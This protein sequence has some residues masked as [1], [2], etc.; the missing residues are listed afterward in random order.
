MPIPSVNDV[1]AVKAD[2]IL[3]KINDTIENE[4]LTKMIALIEEKLNE[5]DY[6]AMDVCAAFLKLAMGDSNNE[7]QPVANND[8]G[9][10]GAEQGMVRLFINLGKN[11][12][13]R[14]GDIL[15]AIAGETGMPGK[16]IGSIDMFDK[17]TFVEVPREYANDVIQIM[18]ESKIK[19]KSINIEPAS[20]K[21]SH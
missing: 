10:T 15:G 9:D 18:K 19:G 1:T 6:T 20:K 2:K 5:A 11:Q 21:G 4:D 7:E 17:Y 14:P 12:K 8:F 3:E 16:L 13:V